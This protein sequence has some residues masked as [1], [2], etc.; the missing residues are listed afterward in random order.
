MLHVPKVNT[1]SRRFRRFWSLRAALILLVLAP[2]L[3]GA[4]IL[5]SMV[6]WTLEKAAEERMQEDVALMAR[7]ISLPVSDSLEQGEDEGVRQA[8]E[9]VFRIGRIYGAYVY[10]ASGE[11]IAAVGAVNPS[12]RRAEVA[13]IAAAG[14]RRGTYQRIQ[15]QDVY[16]YFVPLTDTDGQVS[17]LLH[18]TRRGSDFHDLITDLRVQAIAFMVVGGVFI[19]VLVLLGHRLAIGRHFERLMETMAR[20][21]VGQRD[22]RAGGEGPREIRRLSTALNDMLDG[23]HRAEQELEDRR[24]TQTHLEDKLRHSEKLAAIGRLASGVA[25]ELGTPLS[26]IDGKAQ[27]ALRRIEGDGPEVRALREVRSEVARMEHIVRQLLDF[28][29]GSSRHYRDTSAGLLASA[30]A[31]ALEHDESSRSVALELDGEQPGP[32]CR[33][34]PIRVEQVLVNLLRNAAQAGAMTVC[35]RWRG[36]GDHV[37]FTIEDDGPGVP[38]EI[39]DRLF[40]PFFTTKAVGEGTGLGLAVV[41]GIVTEH[42]GE[43][44]FSAADRGGT[45]VDVRFPM[46]PDWDEQGEQNG[47]GREE[48]ED[49]A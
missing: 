28:G 27:R 35:L 34:D 3:I 6:L 11:P 17:G 36:D 10:S 4:A 20:V 5:T 44:A 32:P 47:N 49:G 19:S 21:E 37:V 39:R 8:L 31:S 22:F 1:I 45:R 2:L 23:I 29:R 33:V 26:V 46:K 7:A 30:A 24:R 43:I 12:P 14:E 16:S 48:R 42:G 9:S 13:D 25:H 40:E 15:G 38:S 18:V 41:H